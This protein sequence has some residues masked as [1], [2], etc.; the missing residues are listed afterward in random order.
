MIL[1]SSNFTGSCFILA[2][3]LIV[4]G[5]FLKSFLVPTRIIGTLG[6]KCRTSGVHFSGMFSR[7]SGESILGEHSQITIRRAGMKGWGVL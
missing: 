7:E 5:S 4:L 3:S 2:S 6:Q 1:P